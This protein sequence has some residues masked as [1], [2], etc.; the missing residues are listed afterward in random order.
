MENKKRNQKEFEIHLLKKLDTNIHG[1]LLFVLTSWT[2]IKKFMHE[3]VAI[4][5]EVLLAFCTDERRLC[6]LSETSVTLGAL[7]LHLVLLELVEREKVVVGPCKVRRRNQRK[8]AHCAVRGQLTILAL[9][10]WTVVTSFLQ[11]LVAFKENDGKKKRVYK[12]PYHTQMEK[13]CSLE[14]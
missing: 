14:Y 3:E 6:D 12:F 5:A 2:V 10:L 9:T 1:L 4:N 11:F 7:L 13:F 8:S